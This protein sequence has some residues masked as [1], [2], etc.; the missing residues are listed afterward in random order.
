M[1]KI[2]K[3]DCE[4]CLWRIPDS[5]LGGDPH[6][7]SHSKNKNSLPENCPLTDEQREEAKGPVEFY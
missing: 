5:S 1:S 6:I 3:E 7:C 4:G 2:T